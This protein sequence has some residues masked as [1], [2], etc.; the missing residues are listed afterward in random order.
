VAALHES[1]DQQQQPMRVTPDARGPPRVPSGS[2]ASSR[3]TAS[4]GG[5]SSNGARSSAR[6]AGPRGRPGPAPTGVRPWD[7]ARAEAPRVPPT[8]R[9]RLR[10]RRCRFTRARAAHDGETPPADPLHG[11]H[12][13]ASPRGTCR[14][15]LTAGKGQFT[16]GAV[17]EWQTPIVP[18]FGIITMGHGLVDR[19][20]LQRQYPRTRGG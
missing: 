13:G 14:V 6:T 15:M 16:G 5:N 7:S 11:C 12:S 9:T 18:S 1:E 8:P 2:T 4:R 10:R 17:V 20:G 19:W 3:K